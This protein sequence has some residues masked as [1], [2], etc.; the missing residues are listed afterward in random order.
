[1]YEACPDVFPQGYLT[2]TEIELWG[3]FHQER[4]DRRKNK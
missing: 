3:L 2:R 1:M 4:A